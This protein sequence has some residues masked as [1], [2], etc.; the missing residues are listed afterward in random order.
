M[1]MVRS[2]DAGM[3]TTNRFF[4]TTALL[5]TAPLPLL[6]GVGYKTA[7]WR[8]ILP[9]AALLLAIGCL[10][11]WPL[12]AYLTWGRQERWVKILSGYVLSLPLYY[13]IL[14]MLYP[15]F[16]GTFRPFVDKR[17]IIYL[18]ATPEFYILILLLFYLTTWKTGKWILRG[19]IV[20]FAAGAL[21]PLYL[22]GATGFDWPRAASDQIAID[23][24]RIVDVSSGQILDGQSVY[25]LG[26][27]ISEIGP[28]SLHPDWM[29]IETHGQYL[30][31]GLIDVHTHLQSPVEVRA[32]FQFGYFMNSMMSNY[33]P[34]R[35]AYLE[36]GVTT[37]RDLGGPAAKSFQMR[38]D[39]RRKK[40]LGP[41]LFT[42]GRLVTS[43]HGHPVSTIWQSSI[44]RDGAILAADERSMIDGLNRNL[45]EGP[46]DAVKF[47]HGTIGRAKEELSAELLA[48]GI[49]WATEHGLIS[50]VHAETAV[51][52]EDAIRSGATGIEHSA[53]LQ[54]VPKSLLRLVA[55]ARPFMDPTF[56]E[57]ET[58]LSLEKLQAG[59]KAQRMEHSY[60]S[61]RALYQAGARLVIGTDSPMTA[62]GVG[63]HD[64][65]AHFAKAG[66]PPSQI[67][68]FATIN[69]A[70][71]L[72]KS[73]D[74]G[75]VRTGYQADLILTKDNPLEKLDTLRHPVWTMLDGQ[76]VSGK[77]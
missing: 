24:A 9:A 62:Y 74:L 37:I 1:T 66:F 41:R 29:R 60:E 17:W 56:G 4:V 59:E 72:G 55:D 12:G 69:N 47:V 63:F 71:Y 27:R 2:E 61:V 28:S 23:G 75:Q 76:V 40:I 53:Y 14:A 34:Q 43:P 36:N 30:L 70:A 6:I 22:M 44:S 52:V 54:E 26:G 46:P 10:Y 64:E 5:F 45:A 68:M 18:S 65:L 73:E 35:K 3:H 58:G 31:P 50:I 77:R 39:I 57:Y 67:L 25:V 15:L 51:E 33:A 11:W 20:A 42:A 16:G 7:D 38:D 49:R 21:S 13:V 48:R 32:G 19:A 8:S